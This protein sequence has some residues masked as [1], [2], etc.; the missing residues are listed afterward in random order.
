MKGKK[1]TDETKAVISQK[2][3]DKWKEDAYK[4]KLKIGRAHV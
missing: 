3:K 4:E 2:L 1:H